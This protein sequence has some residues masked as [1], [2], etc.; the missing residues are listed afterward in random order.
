VPVYTTTSPKLR[1]NDFLTNKYVAPFE[2]C[3]QSACRDYMNPPE[4]YEYIDTGETCAIFF[5]DSDYR[6]TALEAWARLRN[7]SALYWRG[8]IGNAT[9]GSKCGPDAIPLLQVGD[10]GAFL[11]TKYASKSPDSKIPWTSYFKKLRDAGRVM[12]AARI[13]THSLKRLHEISDMLKKDPDAV[14]KMWEGI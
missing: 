2:G 4:A 5:E 9:H 7:D 3:I 13:D 14:E 11:G 1:K 8:R 10:L 6:H 12:Q